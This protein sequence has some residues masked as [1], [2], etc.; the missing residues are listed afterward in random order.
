MEWPREGIRLEGP[1]LDENDGGVVHG[2]ADE[3]GWFK[4]T[5]GSRIA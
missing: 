2:R 5:N 3:A 1:D 4:A